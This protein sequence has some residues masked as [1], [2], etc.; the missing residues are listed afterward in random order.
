MAA[1]QT[2]TDRGY[3]ADRP[4]RIPRRGWRDILVR[5]KDEASRD[6]VSLIAAG[7]AFYAL[8]A[9]FPALAATVAIYGLVMNPETVQS[10]VQALS[11]MV[12]DAAM[13]I[14]E[15]QLNS[16]ANTAPSQLSLVAAGSVLLVLWSATKGTKAMMTALDI[17]YDE[18][19]DRGFIKFNA[20]ALLLTV[21]AILGAVITLALIVAVPALLGSIGLGSTGQWLV[22]ILRWPLLLVLVMAGL[23]VLFR[24]GPSRTAPRW[25][26]V[27]WGAAGA[28]VLWIAAS[29]LFSWYVANFGSYNST[30]GSLGAVVILLLWFYISAY[31]F[32]MGAE[33]NAQMERQTARDTTVGPERP[34]GRRGAYAA[35][36]AAG[37]R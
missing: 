32:L 22:S 2:R 20:L 11:G 8:L 23:A 13:S 14:I 15:Q 6:N 4:A 31:V 27:S 12:P 30:Y 9:I 36:D 19:E 1:R 34:M 17:V 29:L 10:Q 5:T 33:V 3:E 18:E 16:L 7:V 26:W 37:R 35:D 24:Y 21:G 25:R 28:V